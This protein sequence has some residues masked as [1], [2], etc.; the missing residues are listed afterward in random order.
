MH[1]IG[2]MFQGWL[3]RARVWGESL[4]CHIISLAAGIRV[5]SHGTCRLSAEAGHLGDALLPQRSRVAGA[6]AVGQAGGTAGE[7][8][9][10]GRRVPRPAGAH[11][12]A[13]LHPPHRRLS[14]DVHC[15]VT[16]QGGR[17]AS[18]TA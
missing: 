13:L 14:G 2:M 10:G 1:G 5:Q 7:R 4:Q 9:A 8:A 16:P 12:P 18:R 15:T 11:R 3:G 6:L 17:T